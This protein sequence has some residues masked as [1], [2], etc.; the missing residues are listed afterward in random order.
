MTKKVSWAKK[1]IA[2]L[3]LDTQ[4]ELLNRSLLQVE[5]NLRPESNK[6]TWAFRDELR[7]QASLLGE[8]RK[9]IKEMPCRRKMPW[10]TLVVRIYIW[11][12]K[13][14]FDF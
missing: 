13:G 6:E 3:Q 2:L 7:T 5:L 11:A 9:E 12:T 10:S 1:R 14:R 4:E 8:V